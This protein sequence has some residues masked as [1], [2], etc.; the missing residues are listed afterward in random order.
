MIAPAIANWIRS[1]TIQPQRILLV[2]GCTANVIRSAPAYT[3]A[4]RIANIR[5]GPPKH[6]HF[7]MDVVHKLPVPEKSKHEDENKCCDECDKEFFPVHNFFLL[8]FLLR[9]I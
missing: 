8:R 2:S 4:T 1:P 5:F 3:S 6:R 9:P 7:I